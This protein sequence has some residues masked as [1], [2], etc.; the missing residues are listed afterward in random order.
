MFTH[1]HGDF[2]QLFTGGAKLM[3]VPL[4]DERIVTDCCGA[5]T[6]FKLF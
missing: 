2:C 4:S 3:H 5:V 1:G 6:V